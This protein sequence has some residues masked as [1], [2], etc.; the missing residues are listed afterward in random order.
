MKAFNRIFKYIWPQ[1]P[2][3]VVVVISAILVSFLLSLSFI[4]VIPLL[5]VMMNEEGLHGWVDRK[6]CNLIYGLDFY[7]PNFAD[8]TGSNNQDVVNQLQIIKVTE[9]SIADAAGLKI[10]DRIINAGD[11]LIGPDT[12]NNPVKA[13]KLLEEL[14]T[15]KDSLITLKVKRFAPDGRPE[16]KTIKMSTAENA[17]YIN[18][19]GWSAIERMNFNVRVKLMGYAQSVLSRLPREQSSENQTKAI[20][21]IIVL[22]GIITVIRCTA[23]Y[24]QSFIAEKVVQVGINHL[25]RDAFEHVLNMPMGFFANE[26]P[27]DTVSRLVRDTG[28][29]GNG[30]KIMLGKALREPLNA[31]FMLG[32]AAWLHWQLTLVFLCG[33]PPTIWLVRLLGRK[34]KRASKKSLMAWSQMLGKLQETMEG[35]KVVKVYNQQNYE[36]NIFEQINR[37]LLKQ[38][39]KIS[40]VDAATMPVLEIVGMA[41]GSVA[42][43]V[44]ASWVAQKQLEGSEFL[45]LLIL[46]GTAAESVR[47]TSDIWNKIQE[48]TAAAERVFA[49]MDQPLELQ[50]QRAIE[51]KPM[52]HGI[53]FR[54]VVF[55]YPGTDK[56]VLKGINLSV[57]AGHN[58]AIVGPNGSG[59]TTLANLIPRF[60][61]PDSGRILIDG[62]D[63]HDATLFSLRSQ[64]GM[65]TQNVITFN[66]TIAANI[67]YGKPRATKEEIIAAAKRAFAHE[68]ISPLP[69]SYDTIIGEQ[70][71]GLSGGQLQRISIARAILKNPA[72]LIFDEATSHID[73]DSEAKIHQAIEEVMHDRTCFI[74]AHR[75][76]TV[77]TA[78]VIVVMDDGKII[79]QGQHEELMQTCPLYQSL[80]ETQLIT[81]K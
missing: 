34:M 69:A 43:L 55:S 35:L 76:S 18:N 48:A 54:N 68:F 9:G 12:E 64:I 50:K 49:V 71:A 32:V 22:V 56:P 6:T 74:I 25:R 42:L 58:I 27:S 59:K 66:D 67:A 29:M 28:A 31:A 4:T 10:G 17:A 13:P 21:F 40:R 38:L 16:I 45:V 61:D 19:L 14:A 2:R 3:I 1:W 62:K 77:I 33:A 26:R 47:K 36:K 52:T 37:R 24:Y 53:E 8:V 70:G 41:A 63:I 80:Y 39:L 46:L 7:V 44:G 78:D 23:K 81:L 5:K 73:A 72:I 60:Y 75:F 51:L 15:V 30:I 20:I 79:A 11:A 65:V 57:Q